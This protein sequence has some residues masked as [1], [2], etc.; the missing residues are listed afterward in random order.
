MGFFP[1]SFRTTDLRHS[2]RI[3]TIR[4]FLKFSGDSKLLLLRRAIMGAY[5]ARGG[6]LSYSTAV[7]SRIRAT[8]EVHVSLGIFH[9][10]QVQD[11][12]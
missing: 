8:C 6:E 10:T 2:P 4:T 3:R 5:G 9:T 12:V 11:Y 7:Q 1:Q